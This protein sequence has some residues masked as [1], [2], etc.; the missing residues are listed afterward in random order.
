MKH[1][2]I[3]LSILSLSLNACKEVE[4]PPVDSDQELITTVILSFSEAS[5]PTIDSFAFRDLDGPGGVAPTLDTIKLKANTTYTCN[6][7]FLDESDANDVE[8][9][10][11]EVLEEG[12]DHHL[13]LLALAQLNINMSFDEADNNGYP[14]PVVSS[15]T[16]KDAIDGNMTL[17]LQHKEGHSHTDCDEGET[18]VEVEFPVQVH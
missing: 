2:L 5:N 15:W 6:V 17:K 3:I 18:D 16:T 1:L 7:S 14:I 11:L 4:E 10:T 12:M 13:C 8:D 9:I